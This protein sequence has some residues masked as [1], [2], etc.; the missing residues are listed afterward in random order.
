MSV[1]ELGGEVAT[2]SQRWISRLARAASCAALVVFTACPESP[3]PGEP[4]P[5]RILVQ[6]SP[7]QR[8]A[9]GATAI[10]TVTVER[11]NFSGSVTLSVPTGSLP[12]GVTVEFDPQVLTGGETQSLARISASPTTPVQ[13]LSDPQSTTIYIDATAPGGL[14]TRCSTF[15]TIAF[16]MVRTGTVRVYMSRCARRSASLRGF[17]MRCKPW[18]SSTSRR[19]G[20][21]RTSAT[22]KRG[23][24]IIRRAVVSVGARREETESVRG[25]CCPRP[26]E[27]T[28]PGCLP[29]AEA[30]PA[31]TRRVVSGGF[32]RLSPVA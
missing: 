29:L 16:P 17:R 18:H 28:P 25:T 2:H 19:F 10:Y 7:S 8:L 13:Y 24:R 15:F 26:P 30:T 9:Q 22:H 14:K 32:E 12:D 21:D 20:R 6:T 23:D 3:A 27:P 1:R 11:R 31:L 4:N 5:G